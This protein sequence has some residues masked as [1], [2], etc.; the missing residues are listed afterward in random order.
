MTYSDFID[1]SKNL[2][3]LKDFLPKTGRFFYY[4]SIL[5]ELESSWTNLETDIFDRRWN[6]YQKQLF[7]LIFFWGIY[8]P[9][10]IVDKI[11]RFYVL[12]L[13]ECDCLRIIGRFFLHSLDD[14]KYFDRFIEDFVILWKNFQVFI[15]KMNFFSIDRVQNRRAA[16][17]FFSWV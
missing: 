13:A 4:S 3:S 10:T 11:E 8:I 16:A 17:V 6:F 2:N 9:Q 15:S 5:K 14:M 12:N 7:C 1:L